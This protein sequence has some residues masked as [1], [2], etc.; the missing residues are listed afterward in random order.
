MTLFQAVVLGIVEGITEFLPISSTGHMILAARW[1]GMTSTP[2]VKSFEIVIQLGAI[3]AIALLYWRRLLV[4]KE[5]NK[6]IL[7]AFVPTGLL[8]FVFYKFVKTYL[9]GS[10]EITAI[11]LLLGGIVM[12][13]FEHFFGKRVRTQD[14]QSLTLADLPYSRCFSLGLVQAVAMIPGVSRSATTILGGMAVGL[15]RIEATEFS[16]LVATPTLLAA[17]GWDLLK[18]GVSFSLSE[19]MLLGVGFGVAFLSAVLAVRFLMRYLKHHTFTAFGVYRILLA[20][21][22]FFSNRG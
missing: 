12:I 20:G 22:F 4:E 6:R 15:S 18:S 5:I 13:V 8:G 21:V 11:A 3:A 14:P 9:L 2:F 1:L 19:W 7:I 17:S 16:F 10:A